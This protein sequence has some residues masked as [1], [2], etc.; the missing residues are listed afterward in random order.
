MISYKGGDGVEKTA[1]KHLVC[2]I[3]TLMLFVIGPVVQSVNA[4]VIDIV[5]IEN[6]INEAIGAGIDKESAVLN[7]VRDAA[8][9]ILTTEKA[10]NPDFAMSEQEIATEIMT[11]LGELALSGQDDDSMEGLFIDILPIETALVELIDSGVERE[12]AIEQV[13][14]EFAEKIYNTEK[15]ENPEFDIPA[16]L[17]A[18]RIIEMLGEM[19]IDDIEGYESP[20]QGQFIRQVTA[21]SP[22]NDEKPASQI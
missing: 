12:T 14:N 17:I 11:M 15:A 1:L 21:T 13:A 2:T 7:A 18:V 3:V 4:L 5:P 6:S 19:A 9:Q 22:V 10:A 8:E 16:N 20:E